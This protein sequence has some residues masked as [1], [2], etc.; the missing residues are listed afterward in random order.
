MIVIMVTS[1]NRGRSWQLLKRKVS[2]G[3][4]ARLSEK[5]KNI[6]RLSEKKVQE[7]III[8]IV[9]INTIMIVIIMI[10]IIIILMILS[11]LNFWMSTRESSTG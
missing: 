3:H 4:I 1:D 2:R 9:I 5:N 10:V 8:M 7:S 11:A 6:A